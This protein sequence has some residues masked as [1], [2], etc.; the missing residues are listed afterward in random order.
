MWEGRD[1]TEADE[2]LEGA[3]C[4]NGCATLQARELTKGSRIGL[5]N[6][7]RKGYAWIEHF[8]GPPLCMQRRG[9]VIAVL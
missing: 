1:P 9:G 2:G 7:K 5:S 4:K 6:A 3:L 8:Q